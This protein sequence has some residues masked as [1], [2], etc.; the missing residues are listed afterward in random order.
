MAAT[1][2][3]QT[4]EAFEEIRLRWLAMIA[5]P[6]IRNPGA[7]PRAVLLLDQRWPE[8]NVKK[9]YDVY[10]PWAEAWKGGRPDVTQVA[11]Q[12]ANV[13]MAQAWVDDINASILKSSNPATIKCHL[14]E[15]TCTLFFRLPG[16]AGDGSMATFD[17]ETSTTDNE[18]L[19]SL[20]AVETWPSDVKAAA[21]SLMQNVGAGLGRG[22]GGLG[23]PLLAGFWKSLT[24]IQ[25]VAVVGAGG[26]VALGAVAFGIAQ[27]KTLI[28]VRR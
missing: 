28:P 13:N 16:K 3:K 24:P 11:A 1:L 12:Q 21:E 19:A 8:K 27:I 15:K 26:T 10:L 6:R 14:Q 4:E 20:P 9:L 7:E 23:V 18:F 22:A 25:K 2:T 5:T 17:I